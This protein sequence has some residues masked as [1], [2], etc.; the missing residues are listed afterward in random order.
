MLPDL[1]R[2]KSVWLSLARRAWLRATRDSPRLKP[3]SWKR[4]RRALT[5][6][7]WAQ[8]RL[9]LRAS[10]PRDSAWRR[11][12]DCPALLLQLSRAAARLARRD[13]IF[14]ASSPRPAAVWRPG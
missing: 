3:A 13:L 4:A 7:A 12:L 8:V 5:G 2:L 9:D 6:P 10:H 1:S 14:G 11:Q